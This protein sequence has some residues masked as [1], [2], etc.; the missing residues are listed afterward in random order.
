MT[1]FQNDCRK[2]VHNSKVK[3]YKVSVLL[4]M[5]IIFYMNNEPY[6]S[7]IDTVTQIILISVRF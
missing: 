5:L 7:M 3:D 1:Y 6:P 2:I 4:K